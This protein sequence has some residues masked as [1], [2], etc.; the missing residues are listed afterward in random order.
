[1]AE[2]FARLRRLMVETQIRARGVR[3]PLVLAAMAEVPRQGMSSRFDR[4]T[5]VSFPSASSVV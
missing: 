5:P 2:D 3:D 1:M 4:S